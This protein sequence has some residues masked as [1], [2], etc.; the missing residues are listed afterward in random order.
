MVVA[1]CATRRPRSWA[2]CRRATLVALGGGGSGGCC[3]SPAR[4]GSSVI[5]MSMSGFSKSLGGESLVRIAACLGPSTRKVSPLLG[6]SWIDRWNRLRHVS[7]VWCDP[8]HGA[9]RRSGPDLRR[10]EVT[11]VGTVVCRNLVTISRQGLGWLPSRRCDS[12]AATGHSHL[13]A[14]GGATQ[15]PIWCEAMAR[16]PGR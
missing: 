16:S 3:G 5:S 6:C 2:N 10:G 11:K 15:L 1:G 13:I 12:A 9:G 8:P 14:S 4:D 7:P